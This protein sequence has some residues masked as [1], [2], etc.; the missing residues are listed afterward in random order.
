VAI[1]SYPSGD[2]DVIHSMR[3]T[4]RSWMFIYAGLVAAIV[5]ASQ[6]VPGADRA[7]TDDSLRPMI[8]DTPLGRSD[9]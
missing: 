9:I 6:P 7:A 3:S 5:L 4:L 2:S 8:T 1:K